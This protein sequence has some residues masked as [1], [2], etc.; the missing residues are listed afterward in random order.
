MECLKKK[1]ELCIGCQVMCIC[2]LDQENNLVNG[3]QG[4]IQDFQV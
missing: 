4:V 2:N 3:S 1:L